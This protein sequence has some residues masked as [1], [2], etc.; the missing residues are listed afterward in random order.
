MFRRPYPILFLAN[1][2]H[3]WDCRDVYWK[4]NDILEACKS[5]SSDEKPEESAIIFYKNCALH[6]LHPK[7][8]DD[9]KVQD[10]VD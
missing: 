6:N 9:E 10:A 2:N 4:T 5:F 7:N 3:Y 8:P 1:G